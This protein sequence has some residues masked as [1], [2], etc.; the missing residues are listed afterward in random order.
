M[1][2]LKTTVINIKDAPADWVDRHD[3]F[4]YIG[5]TGKGFKGTW[6][7]PFRLDNEKDRVLVLSR[8]KN[9]FYRMIN[10]DENFFEGVMDMAG[11]TLVCFC[12]PKACHGDTIAEFLN[13]LDE[14]RSEL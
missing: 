13:G 7:N 5:R 10:K 11:K 2:T 6:G 3:E 1:G 14:L 9:Y 12:K 8:Y 4:V